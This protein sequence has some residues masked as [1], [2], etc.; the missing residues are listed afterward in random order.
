MTTEQNT[1]AT[2]PARVV[3]ARNVLCPTPIVRLTAA[4]RELPVGASLRLIAT[5]PGSDADVRAWAVESGHELV[6]AGR[7]GG[8]YHFVVRRTH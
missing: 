5:D 2:A 8:E 7:T 3:D 6:E 4:I 1:V